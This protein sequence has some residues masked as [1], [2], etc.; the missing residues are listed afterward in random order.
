[1]Y[2]GIQKGGIFLKERIKEIR[3]NHPK[4]KTQDTFADFLGISK[5]NISSYEMGRRT[6]SEA[7]IKLICEKCN[8]NENWLL[9]GNGEMFNPI[10][11]NEEIADMI[12]D[13]IKS[14][15]KDFKRRL[16]SALARLDDTGWENLEKLIDMISENK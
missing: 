1:M 14:D 10:S 4:G 13:V 15:E 8:V 7:V 11:K 9:T 12:S 3:K 5:Q 16:I 2:N 6:P